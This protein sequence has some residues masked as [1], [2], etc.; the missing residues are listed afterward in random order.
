ME[1]KNL[2]AIAARRGKG[3]KRTKYLV[4]ISEC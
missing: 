2:A 4:E 1:L 3:C